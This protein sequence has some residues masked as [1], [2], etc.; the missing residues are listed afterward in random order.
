MTYLP[1]IRLRQHLT[2]D[3]FLEFCEQNEGYK[4]ERDHTGLILMEPTFS[5]TGYFNMKLSSKFFNW[6][7]ASALGYLFDSSTGFTLPNNSLRSPDVTWVSKT[8]WQTLTPEAKKG[9][10]QVCPDFVAE[11]RSDS[12]R[13]RE[14]KSKMKEY[15]DN[16]TQLAWLIDRSAQ[17]V[18][19]YRAD[20]SMDTIENFDTSLS[21]EDVLVGFEMDLGFLKEEL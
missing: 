4:I 11:L 12:D 14:L 16:G 19:I 9:F 17:K 5:E 7:D 1:T 20:G 18:Y 8:R 10:A 3:Q 2:D 21:G 6:N 13:I 15:I